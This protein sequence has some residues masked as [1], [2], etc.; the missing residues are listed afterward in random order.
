MAGTT[1]GAA[2]AGRAVAPLSRTAFRGPAAAR[3]TGPCG[4]GAAGAGAGRRA[5]RQP[6][7]GHRRTGA[8]VVAGVG[9]GQ[10][11]HAVDGH[12]QPAGRG[13]AAAHR[14]AAQGAGA[15]RGGS[16]GMSVV[17]WTL[18]AL[19]SHWRRHPVQ[20]FSL[21]TGLWL[22][23]ALLTG[24]QAINGQARESYARANDLIG[25]TPHANLQP[26][27]GQPLPQEAFTQLRRQGWPVSPVLEG[28]VQLADGSGRLRVMG[29]E[30]LSLPP[31]SRMAGAPAQPGGLIDF[32]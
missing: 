3:G 17:R 22:A 6:R 32:I 10:R 18:R 13:A 14:G 27:D 23:T 30:P 1:G 28:T 15:S 12:P 7:R 31:G 26:V 9:G 5:Y 24:V 2:R 20:F 11:Q 4:G 8:A 21:F 16:I 25:G 19:L 29:I